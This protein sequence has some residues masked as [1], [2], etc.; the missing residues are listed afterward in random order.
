MDAIIM[1][2]GI[3]KPDDPLYAY[4][5]GKS[6]AL[7]E[8]AGKPLIQWI[9]GAIEDSKTIDRVVIVGL[10]TSID[11]KCTKPMAFVPNHDSILD[12]V[13]AGVKKVSEIN[14]E[15]VFA[16]V[17]TSDIPAITGEMIDWFVNTSMGTDDDIYYSVVPREVMEKRFPNSRRSFIHLKGMEVCGGDMVLIRL[18]VAVGRDEL[19]NKLFA[20]RK[21][22]FK[23]VSLIGYDTLVMLL[24]RRLTLEKGVRTV[25]KRLGLRGRALVSPYAETGMDIDKPYQYELLRDNLEKQM[26]YHEL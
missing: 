19:W 20:A 6:K 18:T 26:G 10:E 8:I 16:L 7:L 23:A 5:Q 22:A 12:N 21:N 9:L 4:T 15:A 2:G 14:P 17:L 25:A 3:P 1:A 11:L 24:S 13:R